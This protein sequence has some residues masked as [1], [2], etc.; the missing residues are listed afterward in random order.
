MI[1]AAALDLLGESAYV[2]LTTFRKNGTPVPTPVWV[3]R[4][5]D[6]LLVTSN[7]TAG[8]VKR[9]GHTPRV[10][11]TPCD[12]RGRVA[13]GAVEHEG[14]AVVIRDADQ[15][16]RLNQLLIAKYGIQARLLFIGSRIRRAE[17]ACLD[18]TSGT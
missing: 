8:K 3:V 17:S 4:D 1:D 2:R 16:R 14:T 15:Q 9:L 12:V 6:H 7:A 13:D 18:I 5:G 10:T 11:L